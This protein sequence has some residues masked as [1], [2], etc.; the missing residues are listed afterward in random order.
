MWW[1]INFL[2]PISIGT[3]VEIS[4]ICTCENTKYKIKD[5]GQ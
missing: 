4:R 5:K 2:K 1:V 3:Q